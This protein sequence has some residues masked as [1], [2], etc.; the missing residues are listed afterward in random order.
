MVMEASRVRTGD[1][2]ITRVLNAMKLPRVVSS[3]SKVVGGGEVLSD[4][5]YRHGRGMEVEEQVR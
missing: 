3:G 1:V 4:S 2:R 5:G